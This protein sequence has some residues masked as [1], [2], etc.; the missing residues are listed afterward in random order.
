MINV[1][2]GLLSKIIET[3]NLEYLS[4]MGL[5]ISHFTGSWRNVYRFMQN[6]AVENGCV[7]PMH[8][9]K[10]YFPKSEFLSKRE[11]KR[12][13]LNTWLKELY[14]KNKFNRIVD[15]IEKVQEFLQGMSEEDAEK[16]LYKILSDIGD[17]SIGRSEFVSSRDMQ[18]IK[19]KYKEIEKLKGMVGVPTGLKGLDKLLGGLEN[20]QFITIFGRYGVGKTWLMLLLLYHV[21]MQGFEVLV[22]T[23]EMTEKQLMMRFTSFY[24]RLPYWKIRA[25]M[26]DKE[27]RKLYFKCLNKIKSRKN[28]IIIFKVTGGLPQIRSMIEK[29]RADVI[30]I[31]G[32]YLMAKSHDWKDVAE[33]SKGIKDL[34]LATNKPIIGTTQANRGTNKKSGPEADDLSFADAI[35][36]DADVI[37]GLHQSEEMRNDREMDIK[38]L[39][40]R[41]GNKGTTKVSW[42]FNNVNFEEIYTTNEQGSTSVSEKGEDDTTFKK[43]LVGMKEKKSSKPKKSG[44]IVGIKEATQRSKERKKVS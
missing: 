13:T 39:K 35:G 36:G 32:F 5:D 30:G 33:V 44:K 16:E 40:Q 27:E 41:E 28:N 9:V 1:E 11:L 21:W 34:A 22:A 23:K 43:K 18:Q 7:P 4:D 25:G 37:L 17:I 15:G 19:N 29:H 26:L 14:R 38:V 6:Y 31:D 24:S 12:T 2:A 42:D 3:G 10:R 8:M 20:G